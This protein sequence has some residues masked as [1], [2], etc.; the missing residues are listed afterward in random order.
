MNIDKQTLTRV[1]TEELTKSD[2][3]NMIDTEQS[4]FLKSKDYEQRVKAIST[5]VIEELYK[6]LWQRKSFWAD[7]IGK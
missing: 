2:V 1:I 7:S 5:K 6:L 4:K 3:K